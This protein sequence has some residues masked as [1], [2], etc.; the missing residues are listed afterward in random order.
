M[1]NIA[2]ISLVGQIELKLDSASSTMPTYIHA[3]ISSC[4]FNPCSESSQVSTYL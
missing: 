2:A 3:G 1:K 4:A